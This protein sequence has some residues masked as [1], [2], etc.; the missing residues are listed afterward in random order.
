MALIYHGNAL[1]NQDKVTT[2]TPA[3]Q[4]KQEISKMVHAFPNNAWSQL[5]IM[6]LYIVFVFWCAEY[7]LTQVSCALMASAPEDA[8]SHQ[9]H[10]HWNLH[11]PKNGA[12]ELQDVGIRD[13][14]FDSF[15]WIRPLTL[16]Q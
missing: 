1:Q 5:H 12:R 16:E 13:G 3:E 11:Y 6:Q 9:K 2:W 8:V 4:Q 10:G 7:Y 14:K 15:N